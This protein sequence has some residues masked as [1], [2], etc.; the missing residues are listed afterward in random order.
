MNN[1]LISRSRL[2]E[3]EKLL[4]TDIVKN[5]EVAKDI[6][7]QVLYDIEN[8][9]TAFDYEKM[10]NR[11]KVLSAGIVLNWNISSDYAEGY[12]QAAKDIIKII[13]KDFE[14]NTSEDIK[15]LV[16]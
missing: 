9:P 5:D 6:L 2:L 15:K 1:D 16:A 7:E 14:I 11:I 13:E 12:I 3:T 10:V 4:M 8:F